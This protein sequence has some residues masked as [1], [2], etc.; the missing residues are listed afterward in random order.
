MK[1]WEEAAESKSSLSSTGRQKDGGGAERCVKALQGQED[2]RMV[3]E[4]RGV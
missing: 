1:V 4:Q 2:K 3:V